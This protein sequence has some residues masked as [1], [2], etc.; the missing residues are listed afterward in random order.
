MTAFEGA[1]PARMRIDTTNDTIVRLSGPSY[2]REG[3]TNNVGSV[4]PPDQKSS[5][6]IEAVSWGEG[7]L[8]RCV[9]GWECTGR[10]DA[11]MATAWNRHPSEFAGRRRR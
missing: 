3:E 11:A 10:T 4:P 7:R 9:C 8:T 5:H 1:L 2:G 6:V